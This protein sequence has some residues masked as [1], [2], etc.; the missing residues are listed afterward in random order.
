MLVVLSGPSGVGK[1]TL[2]RRLREM[3]PERLVVSVSATTRSPRPGERPGIDYLFL[4][5]QQ[6]QQRRQRGDFLE[7]CEVYDQGEW[8][9][10]LSEPVRSGLAEGKWVILG[11]DVTGARAVVAKYPAAL[12]IFVRPST[13]EELEQRLRNRGTESEASVARRLKE[14]RR[15]MAQAGWYR[16]QVVNDLVDRAAAEIGDILV[17][18]GEASQ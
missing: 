17:A 11:I 4:T 13:L 7:C 5:Q 16:H 3:F 14:A 9:G 12:T 1:S 18:S 6:F 15:E 8:Y 2:L 10:T